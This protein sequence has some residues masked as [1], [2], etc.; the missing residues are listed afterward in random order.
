[1]IRIATGLFFAVALGTPATLLGSA[2]ILSAQTVTSDAPAPMIVLDPAAEELRT[3]LTAEG[4]MAEPMLTVYAQH[5]F[6][7]IWTEAK[8][9][10]LFDAL[11][12]AASHGLPAARYGL[13]DL[14]ALD[15]AAPSHATREMAL[16]RAFLAYARDINSGIIEPGS[17]DGDIEISPRRPDPAAL[18]EGLAE[19]PDAASYLAALAPSH[20]D[21]AA[22]LG[23]KQRLE[24]LIE[25]GAWGET[26]PEGS[27]LR[28]D[29]DSPRV[30]ALR[31]RL[32]R[33]DGRDYGTS[34]LFDAELE[35]ALRAFQLRHG[36]NDDGVAGP[37][38]LAAVNA[39]AEARLRQVVVNLERQRWL[40]YERGARHIYVNQADFSVRVIDHGKTSFFSRTVI[41]Q[42]RHKT[43]EFND[44]MTHMV[45]NPTWHVPYSIATEEM[46]PKLQANPNALGS[47]MQI[48]TR[49]GTR[50]NPTLV[51]FSQFSRGNFPFL[52]KEAPNPGNALGLVKFMF[53]NKH[54]IYLHDTPSKSLFARDVRAYSHG[55][56]RVQKPFELAQVLL[57]PQVDDPEAA[58]QRYLAGGRERRVDLEQPVPIY[59][60]Y[61]SAWVDEAGV[62]QYRGD[63]Y[64]R[65]ARVF[66]A[67]TEAGVRLSTVEG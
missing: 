63:V 24:A 19:T 52:I 47:N 34:S 61:Q 5:D 31:A 16:S 23:E 56:V 4:A 49:S 53:P 1:M 44:T 18:L 12:D 36:L 58:F 45:V 6:A 28:L 8:A 20:P 50:I 22:L 2:S 38:T 7:P 57:A 30:A 67:L 42:T 14:L 13:S 66:D 54:N 46:L 55:C 33:M 15:L 32:G 25:G 59:L 10:A 35:T 62:P 37:A 60:T 43:Q 27:T 65:D 48:M 40:N 26:V 41:G 21:Y 29:D 17:A 9:A 51:D 11:E 39:S 3:L 64:G